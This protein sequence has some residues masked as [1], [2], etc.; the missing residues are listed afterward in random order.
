[1]NI[2]V[3][4][5]SATANA[6]TGPDGFPILRAS[7]E[8]FAHK[9]IVVGS[10]YQ[11]QQGEMCADVETY[12]TSYGSSAAVG[13]IE[14]YCQTGSDS[15][16]TELTCAQVDVS[17]TFANAAGGRAW[18]ST[19]AGISGVRATVCET[20]GNRPGSAGTRR[21]GAHLTRTEATT[22]GPSY[23]AGAI[24]GLSCRASDKWVYLTTGNDGLGQSS[25]HSYVCWYRT[26]PWSRAIP[27]HVSEVTRFSPGT[28]RL[29]RPGRRLRAPAQLRRLRREDVRHPRRPAHRRLT[30]VGPGPPQ[31][32]GKTRR[33]QPAT[34][35]RAS[36]LA[37]MLN[38][39]KN[40]A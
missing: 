12:P 36:Q 24:A 14:A 40:P 37:R 3:L 32:A 1:M 35:S 30:G 38:Y 39:A 4:G 22:C 17:G 15:I 34:H 6:S 7:T 10:D 2:G 18:A 20:N 33:R 29:A 11:G 13:Q 28:R 5:T 27:V 31:L 23:W 25:G 9:C 19:Y 21:P 8:Q 16:A 26:T